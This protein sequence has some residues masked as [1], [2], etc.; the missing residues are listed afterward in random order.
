M[1]FYV[2]TSE[3]KKEIQLWCWGVFEAGKS[4]GSDIIWWICL[5]IKLRGF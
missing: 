3:G 5:L 1:F 4:M 2:I